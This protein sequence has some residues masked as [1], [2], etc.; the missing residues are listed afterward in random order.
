MTTNHHEQATAGRPAAQAAS[1]Q[2]AA[3]LGR[4]AAASLL[5]GCATAPGEARNP[6]DPFEPFNRSMYS[7]NDGLD[8][9]V[10]K[11]VATAYRDV[12]PRLAR[13]GVSNFFSNLR[14]EEHTSELQSPCNLVCRLL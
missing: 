7:F 11:P 1:W 6:Q 2:R 5:A 12:T 10:L 3:M 13:D 14:S 4:L 8:R 9:A